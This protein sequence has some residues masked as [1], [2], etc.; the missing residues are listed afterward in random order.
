MKFWRTSSCFFLGFSICIIGWA[1][2]FRQGQ[3]SQAALSKVAIERHLQSKH[4]KVPADSSKPT[5]GK[6]LL[7]RASARASQLQSRIQATSASRLRP[8]TPPQGSTPTV[9][10]GIQLRPTLPAGSIATSVVT[11]D[12]NKDGHMDFVVANGGTNDLWIYFGKGNGTF[13][14]PRVIPLT[15]GLTPV[16]LAT[17]DLRGI[18][19]LDLIVAESDTQTIGVLLGNGDG[20]FGFETTYLLPQPPAAL[21]VD[22]FNRD[23]NLDIV[24]V[25]ASA[26]INDVTNQYLAT[27]LGDGSGSFANPLISTNSGFYS[28]AD[29]I[30]SGD[31]NNDGFPDVLVTGPGQENSQVYLNAGNGTF[32]PGTTVIE[33][34]LFNIEMAGLLAD[35]NGDGCLDA[36]VA[37]LNGDV[38]IAPGDCNGNFGN[39][40]PTLTFV[41]MG[42][43]NSAVALADIN[44]DGHMDIVT[45]SLPI[46]PPFGDDVAGNTLSVAFG[47]GK[48]NFTSGRDYV[49][50]GYSYSLS[51][52]DFNGDGYPDVVSASPDTDT[53]TVYLNDGSGG[54]GFP[55]GEWIGV[56]GVNVINAPISA[57]SF[58]DL[59]G[60]GKP[61][62]VLLDESDGGEYI[63]TT[64]L[65]DGT[66]RF[67]APISSEAGVSITS[68]WMGD[69]RLGDFRN[70]GHQ[71]FVGIGLSLAYSTGTQYILFAPGNGD[72]TFG[73]S[74]SV[75]AP[76]AE[77]EMAVGDFNGDGKLDFVAVGASPNGAGKVLTAFLG[78]ADGTFHNAGSIAFADTA[79]DISRVFAGDFNR[80]G[81]L[82]VL[83][84]TTGNGYA[85]TASYVWEFLGNGDGTFKAGQQ[86][87]SA[88]QPMTMADV[89]GDSWLDILRYDFMWPNGTTETYGPP[90]FTTYLDQPSGGFAKSSSYA[91]YGGV[92][93][94]A[95]PYLQFGDP[96]TSSKVA[97]LN[98]DGRPD[99]IAF[100]E[101]SPLDHDVYAQILMGNGDGTFTPTYDV[102]DFNK[103]SF[104]GY[105]H[106]LDGTNIADLIEISGGTSAM[107]VYKGAAAPSFQLA[108]EEAQVTGTS[109]CG[110][111]FLNVQSGSDTNITL[112][113]SIS[114]VV[115]PATVTVSA[116]SLSQKFCY[117][118]SPTYDWHQVFN[119][120]AQLGTDTATAYASQSYIFGFS[121]AI[122]PSAD[123]VIYP[124]QSTT[125]ITVRLTSSQ[126]YTS[127]VQLSCQWLPPGATCV[128]GSDT[129]TVSPTAV[130]STT[131][132]INTIATTQGIAPVQ[133][134]AADSAVTSRQTFNLTV[135]P[136]IVGAVGTLSPTASPGTATGEISIF[137]IPPYK[138][139][140]SGL[141][142]G[143]TCS[144]SG[145]QVPYP[146]YTDLIMTLTVP[147]GIA[148]GVYPFTVA[149][150]SGPENASVG[151][152]LN[153]T[154]FS[155]QPPSAATDWAPP[156]G[157][158]SVSVPV[159]PLGGFNGTVDVTC[160]LD[161]GGS[162]TGG[163]FDIN[164]TASVPITVSV[165]V[166]SSILPGAHTITVT[167]TDAPLT[168]TAAFP[169]YVADYSG[170]L[171]QSTLTVARGA[172]GSLTATVS[173]TAGFGGTVS[174]TCTGTT[175]VTCSFS[176]STVQPT[177]TSPQPTTITVTASNSA[178]MF[179]LRDKTRSKSPLLALIF[180]CGIILGVVCK[181]HI[182]ALRLAVGLF[183]LVMIL[184]AVS[185]GGGSG[186][187]GGSNT[188]AIT[189]T[190][191]ATGTNTTRTLGT[192]NVTITH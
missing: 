82:D 126:G 174:F 160:S 34:G 49:G 2:Q 56:P 123:Q 104:P 44:G 177:A 146:S 89:N 63:I 136:L 145:N 149:V 169:F 65:N 20:T 164:G 84:Y 73:K 86:L 188:Y 46:V 9:F 37:D 83:V 66:G 45:T 147:S 167:A 31:V 124:T 79:Q 152:T 103:S 137:G 94:Q 5:P 190:G 132:V 80:D 168:H 72:G 142:T 53:A 61:D 121:E 38:W 76:G 13:E 131:V 55:Q 140:C 186:G 11:G 35:V 22:D 19:V 47:D 161:F 99:E 120:Q 88:F 157:T 187:G 170:S 191:I 85:T 40:F 138:P 57:P 3:P 192:L 93:L 135:Q 178:F 117:S 133:I 8:Q 101:V 59:N 119:I 144:F 109:G 172:S 180:P 175:Q 48:G 179:P 184:A 182:R 52:A 156:G 43:S 116:G 41:P 95:I 28:T 166:P 30:A 113:T 33:N 67:S 87:F 6:Y 77:G 75:S 159:Q 91:P 154:D 17:A 92:P 36:I 74:T 173:A 107:H 176:P 90:R 25:M 16:Y 26:S 62:V 23:G 106:N 64:M 50:T 14:L 112:S 143:V 105:T 110:W 162:C 39:T 15:R 165:A 68:E 150:V 139:S 155:L 70:T 54:F 115:L 125:P 27:L 12:F 148:G 130:A 98:G 171:S 129:L 96:M 181:R 111:V 183:L 32:T 4:P 100:Q 151:F 128:F 71:D 51:I 141:P 81:K 24:A 153:I 114:G 163:S 69:Y 118:L 108:L 102:F 21:V 60:D 189:V 18:G 158:M 7:G 78:N 1:Q 127:T 29:S 97:D 134:L 10:P 58:V 42:D 185:C 122:S